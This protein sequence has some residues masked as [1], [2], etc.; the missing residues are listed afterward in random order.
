MKNKIIKSL[1]ALILSSILL[2]SCQKQPIADFTTDKTEYTAGE[3]IKLSNKSIDADKYKWTMPDG[4]TATSQNVDY[5]TSVNT[6]EGTLTFKLEAISKNGK[7]T[8]VATKTVSLK[9]ATGRAMIWTS[10]PNV[11]PIAVS[12][13]NIGYGTITMYYTGGTPDCGANG[14]VT[15]TLKVGTYN[16]SAT[17]GFYTWTGTITVYANQCSTLQLQ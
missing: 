5:Q 16:V 4:Q 12:I 6:P 10:N 9:A 14:C 15:A 8:D 3:T 17:D 1:S 7:K 13:N 2:T 11:N